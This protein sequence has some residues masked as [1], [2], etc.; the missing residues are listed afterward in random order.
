MLQ[1][2]ADEIAHM[3]IAQ[4]FD[5]QSYHAGKESA[6]RARI[7]AAFMQVRQCIGSDATV[8]SNLN[9]EQITDNCCDH[10]IRDGHR[11]T[12]YSKRLPL[13]RA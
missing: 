2:D 1:R 11:Q 6:E 8:E 4:G 10:C 7:Q 5:A 3:L 12:R 13:Q 9:A